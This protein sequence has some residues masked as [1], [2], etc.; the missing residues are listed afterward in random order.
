M[1]TILNGVNDGQIMKNELKYQSNQGRKHEK[2][3]RGP[4]HRTHA[5]SR[6]R[7]RRPHSLRNRPSLALRVTSHLLDALCARPNRSKPS[8]ASRSGRA[9]HFMK[10]W[11][12]I[13]KFCTIF[14]RLHDYSAFVE[15]PTALP[16]H[17]RDRMNTKGCRARTLPL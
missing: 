5:R 12:R 7:R 15:F 9:S 1:T 2:N 6:Y 8:W 10:H 13:L 3:D 17:G 14:R 4:H 16:S 11:T